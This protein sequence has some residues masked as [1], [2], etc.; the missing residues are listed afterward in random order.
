MAVF[1]PIPIYR[2]T[3]FPRPS[4]SA[5][6]SVPTRHMP[7]PLR[8]NGI[9]RSSLP[10]KYGTKTTPVFLRKTD[11]DSAPY[12]ASDSSRAKPRNILRYSAPFSRQMG[13]FRLSFGRRK[14]GCALRAHQNHTPSFSITPSDRHPERHVPPIA[15]IVI[16]YRNLTHR[17]FAFRALRSHNHILKSYLSKMALPSR[18]SA[19]GI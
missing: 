1:R 8:K 16:I 14:N 6:P 15:I 10:C 11:A 17:D 13:M 3:R 18:L 19:T 7:F 9:F 12:F 4:S 2:E 5:A